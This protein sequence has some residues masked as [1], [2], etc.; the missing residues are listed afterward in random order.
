[1]P[2][3]AII[4]AGVI[5]AT[6]SVIASSNAAGAATNA[7]NQNNALE[8]SI[9]NSNSANAAPYI[10]AGDKANT[11]LQGFLG[12]GGDPAATQAAFNDYLNSTGYQFN[13]NQ[14]LDAVSQSKAAAGLLNSGSAVKSL[15]S[16]ATGLADS[17]GQQY[18]GDLAGVAATGQAASSGLAGVGANYAG[19]VSSNNNSAASTSA[20]AGLSAS[21]SVNSLIGNALSAYGTQAGLSSYGGGG[22]STSYAAPDNAFGG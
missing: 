8:T 19:A 6:G 2:V 9:Y 13:L 12:L 4:G 21:G 18:E 14:G 1:M 10:Q 22:G 5:G 16:Y 20:N 11:A 17:Y 15:D 3:G 7:A